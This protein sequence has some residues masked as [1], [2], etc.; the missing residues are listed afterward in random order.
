MM[1]YDD[2]KYIAVSNRVVKLQDI[3]ELLKAHYKN[4][5]KEVIE[6]LGVSRND[7][8]GALRDEFVVTYI[9]GLETEIY[10]IL[11]DIQRNID[12]ISDEIFAEGEVM[13]RISRSYT[14]GYPYG[15]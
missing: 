11:S 10:E 5:Q 8:E 3:R 6:D 15:Y 9:P 4:M 7:F 12:L 13:G 14:A 1:Y 2:P